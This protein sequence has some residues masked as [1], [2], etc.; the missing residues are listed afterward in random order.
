M[1]K[2]SCNIKLKSIKLDK[3]LMSGSLNTIFT[4]AQILE[5]LVK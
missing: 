4:L 5:K 1:K 3:N 2:Q